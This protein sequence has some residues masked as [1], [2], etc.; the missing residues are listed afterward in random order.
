MFISVHSVVYY[1]ISHIL[2]CIIYLPK[3][4]MCLAEQIV[5]TSAFAYLYDNSIPFCVVR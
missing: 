2:K 1:I 3:K 4:K 5:W